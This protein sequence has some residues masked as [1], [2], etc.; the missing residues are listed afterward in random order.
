MSTASN[1]ISR[2]AIASATSTMPN[3]HP[4]GINEGGRSERKILM[5][6]AQIN[7]HAHL[8]RF[9]SKPHLLIKNASQE[10]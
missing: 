5:L 9:H 7:S 8:P 4:S 6:I 3:G 10:K 2:I 1:T